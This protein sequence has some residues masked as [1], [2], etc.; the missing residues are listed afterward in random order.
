MKTHFS[1][2][3]YA[4]KVAALHQLSL[5][6]Y[7]PAIPYA[8][9]KKE[10]ETE[11]EQKDKYKSVEV[12]LD[13]TDVDSDK[14]EWKVLTFEKGT[15]EEWVKWRIIF[16][17]LIDTY[18]LNM[19]EKQVNMLKTLLKGDARD[20]FNTIM[21]SQPMTRNQDNQLEHAWKELTKHYFNGDENS[22]RR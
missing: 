16:D 7:P 3:E 1:N 22:W 13:H 9:K 14:T 5:H 17:D 11:N 18:P 10:I 21:S 4:K 19:A 6:V 12:P 2:S 15:S 20:R 8:T